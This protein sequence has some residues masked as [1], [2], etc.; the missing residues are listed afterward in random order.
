MKG[1]SASGLKLR[2]VQA[3]GSGKGVTTNKD[4]GCYGIMVNQQPLIES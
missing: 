1:G 3:A 2:K 4:M